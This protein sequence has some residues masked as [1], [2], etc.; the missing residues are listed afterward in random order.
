MIIRKM[1]SVAFCCRLL[2]IIGVDKRNQ[3]GAAIMMKPENI[4]KAETE[5][6]KALACKASA[7]LND[8]TLTDDQA[9]AIITECNRQQTALG[10]PAGGLTVSRAAYRAA[11]PAFTI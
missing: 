9:D 1:V 3:Q 7:A 5:E 11:C 4:R 10:M 6:T 8:K 2:Y